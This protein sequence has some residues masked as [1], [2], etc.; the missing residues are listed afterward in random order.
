MGAT[1]PALYTHIMANL[2]SL[3]LKSLGGEARLRARLEDFVQ[4]YVGVY[5]QHPLALAVWFDKVKHSPD[6]NVLVLFARTLS[7]D[8]NKFRGSL[9]WKSGVEGPPFVEVHSSS[10]EHF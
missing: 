8:I 1:W 6:Q 7:Q 2:G 4:Y 5:P 3:D 10:V 9:R